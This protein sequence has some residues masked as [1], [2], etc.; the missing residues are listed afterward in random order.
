MTYD[1]KDLKQDIL[2]KKLKPL[3]VFIGDELALQDV[4]IKQIVSVSGLESHRVNDVK[5]VYGKLTSKSLIKAVPQVF[6]IR[7]DDEYFKAESTW[8]NLLKNDL[9][10]NILILLYSGVEK[11]AKF[12]KAHENVLTEFKSISPSILKNRLNA[13]TGLS[14]N[15]AGILISGG[16]W[17]SI[18][19]CLRWIRSLLS[20]SRSFC[21]GTW[22]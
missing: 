13:L 20:G 18:I 5:S 12:C 21:L 11:K 15:S 6:I 9:K 14:L 2:N 10:G 19:I 8:K 1:I 3:Y 22:V 4:Y 16:T 17:R 7:N